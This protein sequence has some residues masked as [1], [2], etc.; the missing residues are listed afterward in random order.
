[1]ATT[2]T[3]NSMI[4]DQLVYTWTL[5]DADTGA[6]KR[7]GSFGDKSYAMQGTW[8]TATIVLQGSWDPPDQTPATWH[9]LHESDN[10][11]AISNTAN[12]IGVILENPVWI[13]PVSSAGDGAAVLTVVISAPWRRMSL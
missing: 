8:D 2:F 1:M 3:D 11:T 9:T 7:V 6:A 10:T 4:G 12:A 5:G 13:R